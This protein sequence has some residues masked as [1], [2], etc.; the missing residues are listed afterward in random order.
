[1]D[2]TKKSIS[3]SSGLTPFISKK[4]RDYLEDTKTLT[5]L[6]RNYLKTDKCREFN[7]YPDNKWCK[8]NE[9]VIIGDKYPCCKYKYIPKYENIIDD[10]WW[11]G[12]DSINFSF[13][14]QF[15]KTIFTNS[16]SIRDNYFIYGSKSHNLNVSSYFNHFYQKEKKPINIDGN[17]IYLLDSYLLNPI[18][19][20]VSVKDF[21]REHSN[22]VIWMNLI[23]VIFDILPPKHNQMFIKSNTYWNRD[24]WCLYLTFFLYGSPSNLKMKRL[25]DYDYSNFDNLYQYLYDNFTDFKKLV[26][27][28]KIKPPWSD[29]ILENIPEEYLV[30]EDDIEWASSFEEPEIEEE[31]EPLTKEEKKKLR[32]LRKEQ[33]EEERLDEEEM[34][35]DSHKMHQRYD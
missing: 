30:N 26:G 1:M 22:Y 3:P 11:I 15:C 21:C 33:R 13:L 29:F 6:S 9:R 31:E 20:N 14:Y 27:M 34:D 2:K 7:Y 17:E 18:D 25:V 8:Q 12:R 28:D 5:R 23:S 35:W 4:I 32:R 10:E 16:K 19:I 24:M